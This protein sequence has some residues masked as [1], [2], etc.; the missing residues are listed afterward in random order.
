MQG[1]YMTGFPK[2]I[3]CLIVEA[4]RIKTQ[5]AVLQQTLKN[6]VTHLGSRDC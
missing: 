5:A 2:N 3:R 4:I 6:K 1:G